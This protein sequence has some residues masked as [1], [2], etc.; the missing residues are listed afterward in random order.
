MELEWDGMEREGKRRK[1]MEESVYM[2]FV[3]LPP[4]FGYVCMCVC[5]MGIIELGKTELTT[6]TS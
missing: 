4:F 6:H 3:S 1:D 2:C 5:V